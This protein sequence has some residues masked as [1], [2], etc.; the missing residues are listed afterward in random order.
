MSAA[1]GDEI[2]ARPIPA[3]ARPLLPLRELLGPYTHEHQ[4]YL[5]STRP[6]DLTGARLSP[7]AG[8]DGHGAQQTPQGLGL[9]CARRP[10]DHR[11]R[12]TTERCQPLD[13]VERGVPG[14][15]RKPLAR[16]GNCQIL[17]LRPLGNRVG[18][19]S[20]DRVDAHQRGVALRA[21]GR[22]YRTSYPIAGDELTATDL[23]G[24]DVDVLI[25]GLGGIDA[26]KGGA[27]AQQL[28]HA[29]GAAST[30]CAIA[31]RRLRGRSVRPLAR[32]V[33]S[34]T[35]ATRT[36]TTAGGEKKKKK[37]KSRV[38]ARSRRHSRM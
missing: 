11:A 25:G 37:K 32:L 35:A 18:R 1:T 16:I 17:V 23:S 27:V 6:T 2:P 38:Q 7:G 22:A 4:C 20:V 34:A 33:R 10:D 3:R 30:A 12:A 36:A 5:H 29:L 28:Y 13:C 31:G 8:G 26:Q 21:A 15:Q 19:C 14:V 24:G 9:A